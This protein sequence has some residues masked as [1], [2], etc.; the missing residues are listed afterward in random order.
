MA[1]R[2]AWRQTRLLQTGNKPVIRRLPVYN[3]VIR[4]SFGVY[5]ARRAD[6]EGNGGGRESGAADSL[7]TG[8]NSGATTETGAEAVKDI[9][10]PPPKREV[11]PK[12]HELAELKVYLS[13]D[14]YT[15]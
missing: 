8:T 11:D 12:D 6:G 4:R 3:A 10:P 7:S 14:T 15:G 9:P 13:N 5:P 2:I 1:L